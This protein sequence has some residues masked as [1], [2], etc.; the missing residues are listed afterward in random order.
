[1]TGTFTRSN[2]FTIT[3]ARYLA[4]KIAADM[5]LCAA[6]YGLPS[7]ASIRNF[8][9]ELAQ[10]LNAGYIASYEF[11][12]KRNGIR[13]VT[14]RYTVDATGSITTDDRPGKIPPYVDISGASFF[15][16]LTPNATYF[17]LQEYQQVSFTSSLPVQRPHGHPPSDG[18]GYWTSDRNYYS[19][20]CGIGRMTFQPSL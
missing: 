4:S 20:G 7:E 16:H 3:H 10:Y 9:E 12:Y 1:M 6:Y 5:H 17:A 15:N 11:G 14:W 13:V 19:S 18:S 2:S 8:A